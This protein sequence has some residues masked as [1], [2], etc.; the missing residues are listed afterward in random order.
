[1]QLHNELDGSYM[2]QPTKLSVIR[3]YTRRDGNV[4]ASRLQWML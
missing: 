3:N 4:I 2:N 1:M